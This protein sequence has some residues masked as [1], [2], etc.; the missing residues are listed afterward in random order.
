MTLPEKQGGAKLPAIV[1]RFVCCHR[2]N[3][4]LYRHC[5]WSSYE[6]RPNYFLSP[7]VQ[8]RS[9]TVGGKSP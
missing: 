9:V 4:R 8:Y 3:I 7:R 2:F 5:Q 6:H 1:L